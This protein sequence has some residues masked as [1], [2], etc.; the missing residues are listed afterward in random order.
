MIQYRCEEVFGSH[1]TNIIDV[2]TYEVMILG[3]NDILIYLNNHYLENS[4]KKETIS[5]INELN[6]N[7]FIDDMSIED[8]KCYLK[9][10]FIFIYKKYGIN[11]KY[12]LWLTTKE[13]V[14]N[15]YCKNLKK[16][17]ILGFETSNFILS[18]LGL[19]GQLYGYENLPEHKEE[20]FYEYSCR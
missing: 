18:D 2:I 9:R 17:T 16:F 4:L 12:G 8:F 1:I 11:I 13:M 7:G 14:K 3:N 10:V 20:L 19:E 5:F 15:F 6:E